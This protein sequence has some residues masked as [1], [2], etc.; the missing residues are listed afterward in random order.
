MNNPANKLAE[1]IQHNTD[2]VGKTGRSARPGENVNVVLGKN[3]G[4]INA[5]AG[6]KINSGKNTA[7]V[8]TSNGPVAIQEQINSSLGIQTIINEYWEE[9]LNN[10]LP[11]YT[12]KIKYQL[13]F[14]SN[15]IASEQT[16]EQ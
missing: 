13:F 3:S 14:T 2:Q 9:E 5:I 11:V 7:V 10:S 1:I 8:N 15:Y 4:V 6:T 16:D 12:K